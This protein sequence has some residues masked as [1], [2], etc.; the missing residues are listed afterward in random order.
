MPPT[1]KN[2][3]MGYTIR[4]AA[5]LRGIHT[6]TVRRQI[7]RGEILAELKG[8]LYII[9]PLELKKIKVRPAHGPKKTA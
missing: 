3:T 5:E 4:E 6:D 7:R 1:R 2:V 9:P 8:N